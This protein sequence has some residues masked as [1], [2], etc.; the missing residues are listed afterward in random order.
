METVSWKTFGNLKRAKKN[1]GQQPKLCGRW[2]GDYFK[3]G[4]HL[5]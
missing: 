3:D 4:R 5:G 2:E 1:R